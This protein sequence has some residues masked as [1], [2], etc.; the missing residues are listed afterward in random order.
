MSCIP[1]L[2][3]FATSM[4]LYCNI[5]SENFFEI[6]PNFVYPD[7]I[8]IYIYLRHYNM[9]FFAQNKYIKILFMGFIEKLK[10][11][12]TAMHALVQ[13]QCDCFSIILNVFYLCFKMNNLT[14]INR[15]FEK[16]LI[17][18]YSIIVQQYSV[19]SMSNHGN[20]Q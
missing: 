20:K 5:F 10:Q 18:N 4:Y 3:H 8:Y 15:C 11:D 7:Q 12:R 14:L 2:L 6:K 13:K 19:Q 16:L 1:S 9:I 17:E